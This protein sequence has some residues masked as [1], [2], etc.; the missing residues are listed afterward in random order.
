MLIFENAKSSTS[1]STFISPKILINFPS[2]DPYQNS[3]FYHLYTSFFI[4]GSSPIYIIFFFNGIN[5]INTV[6]KTLKKFEWIFGKNFSDWAIRLPQFLTKLF[7][8]NPH[9]IHILVMYLFL[10]KGQPSD[11]TKILFFSGRLVNR[12]GMV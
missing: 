12:V 9:K 4:R 7:S 5:L 1:L 11:F 2:T 6:G 8:T 10:Y 3:Y